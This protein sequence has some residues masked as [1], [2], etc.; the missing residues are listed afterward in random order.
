MCFTLDNGRPYFTGDTIHLGNKLPKYNIG[1]IY[2]DYEL[3]FKK[4]QKRFQL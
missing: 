4:I 2:E 1:K 3:F